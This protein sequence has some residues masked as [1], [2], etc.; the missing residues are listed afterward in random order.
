MAADPTPEPNRLERRK[1]R[2]RAALVRAAQTFIADGNVNVPI[3]EITKAADVGMGSFYNHFQTKDE[4]FEAAVDD[5]LE[6]HGAVLDALGDPSDDPAE[7]FARSFRLTGRLHRK[8]PQLSRVLLRSGTELITADRGLAPRAIR[9]LQAAI[10]SGR[11]TADDPELAVVVAGGALLALGQLL[12]D[13]PD[14]DDAAA[15][16]RIAEDL[17]R[18]LGLPPDEA[19]TLSRAPLPTLDDLP[20][21]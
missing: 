17:L 20:V 18:M 19:R 14:R 8:V 11:F 9:D 21:I 4:L 5:A 1:M 6:A 16:D 7:R 2:T 3:L 10:D 13:R 15:T 12:L